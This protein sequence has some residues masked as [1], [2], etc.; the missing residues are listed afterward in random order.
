MILCDRIDQVIQL[1]QTLPALGRN[2]GDLGIRHK[3]QYLTYPAFIFSYRLFCLLNSIPLIHSNDRRLASVVGNSCDL[4]ILFSYTFDCINYKYN[5][6]CT[7]YGADC[8]QDHE[9]LQ[10]FLDL[11][12]PAQPSCINKHIILTIVGDRCI[13]RI[14]CR[15]GNIRY[16]QSVLPKQFVDQG[17][18]AYIWLSNNRHT[19]PVILFLFCAVLIKI[20]DDLVQHITNSHLIGCRYRNWLS[21]PKIVE[22]IDI[23]H[24]L[25]K[26]IYLIYHKHHRLAGTSQHICHLGV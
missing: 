15:T 5:N 10:L 4:G 11:V 9:M 7:F 24:I 23:C 19:D 16:D 2:K 26:V 22:F 21:D 13:H 12:F 3:G 18:L 25:F 1:H 6:I 14:S 20:F 17:R 8:T